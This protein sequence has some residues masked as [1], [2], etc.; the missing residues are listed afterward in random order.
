MAITQ[1]CWITLP[2]P[3]SPISDP[4]V[5]L[6]TEDQF[7]TGSAGN[8][9]AN[10]A[11]NPQAFTNGG[12]DLQVF[13]DIDCTSRLPIDRVRFVTSDTAPSVQVWVRALGFAEGDVIAFGK[14]DVQ[15]TQPAFGA[16]FGRNAVWADYLAVLHMNTADWLDSTGNSREG[17][18]TGTPTITSSDHPFGGQWT[19]FDTGVAEYLT[20][21]NSANILDNADNV[22]VQAVVYKATAQN[23][24]IVSNRRDNQATNWF[25][26]SSRGANPEGYN[27]PVHDGSG[28][29]SPSVF[30]KGN[31]LSFLSMVWNTNEV[32]TYSD[33]VLANTGAMAGDGKFSTVKPIVI[34]SYFNL[35]AALSFVGKIGLVRISLNNKTSAVVSTEYSNQINSTYINGTTVGY[36]DVG[37]G[38]TTITVTELK[39]SRLDLSLVS[40]F[41]NIAVSVT[42]SKSSRVD[43]SSLS[44]SGAVAASVTE[45]RSKRYDSSSVTIES[46]ALDLI[47]TEIKKSRVNISSVAIKKEIEA[48]ITEVRASRNDLSDV[49][50]PVIITVNTKNIVKIKRKNNTVKIKRTNNIVRVK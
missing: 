2:A 48:I 17:V 14:D 44:I 33:G 18:A 43:V 29:S 13:S 32:K 25:Q 20:L 10:Q 26:L 46:K 45:V 47:V 19:E 49:N 31:G 12:G 35:S 50:I 40:I 16:P 41:G 3:A 5:F 42:E 15:T 28:E 39:S 21:N 4:F 23:G 38:G 36:Q 8:P 11:T 22:S 9:L 34:G 24:G 6:I 27:S 1:K 30:A 7:T 37:A